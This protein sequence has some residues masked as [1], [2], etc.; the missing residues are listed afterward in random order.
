MKKR[1]GLLKLVTWLVSGNL[2]RLAPLAHYFLELLPLFALYSD[3][4]DANGL[5]AF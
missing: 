3:L 5:P 4:E 2:H 1:I